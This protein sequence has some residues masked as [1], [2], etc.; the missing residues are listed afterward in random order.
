MTKFLHSNSSSEEACF[1]VEHGPATVRT[2]HKF[3]GPQHT[4]TWYDIRAYHEKRSRARDEGS[5]RHTH[6][7]FMQ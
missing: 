4:P 5:R 6:M 7:G 1:T 2:V 3:L